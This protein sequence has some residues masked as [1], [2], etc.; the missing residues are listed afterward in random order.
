MGCH[1]EG[2]T[3]VGKIDDVECCVGRMIET[4]QCVPCDETS[5]KRPDPSYEYTKVNWCSYKKT[6]GT[7]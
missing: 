6:K 7:S 4:R 5:L 2:F 1:S 3:C